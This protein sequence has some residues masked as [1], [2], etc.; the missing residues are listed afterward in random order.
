MILLINIVGGYGFLLW[1]SFNFFVSF[2]PLFEKFWSLKK[3]LSGLLLGNFEFSGIIHNLTQLF[4][5]AN[6]KKKNY[7]VLYFIPVIYTSKYLY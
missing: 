1:F 7:Y 4:C 6:F 5:A 2:F 3:K